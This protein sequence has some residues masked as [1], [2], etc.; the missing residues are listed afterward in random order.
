MGGILSS[1]V[2]ERERSNGRAAV[3]ISRLDDGSVLTR[4]PSALC[5]DDAPSSN[6]VPNCREK[7][8]YY[9]C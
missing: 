3:S 8:K 9:S 7:K 4:P 1:T 6:T 5:A 2:S